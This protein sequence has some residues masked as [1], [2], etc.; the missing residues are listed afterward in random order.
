MAEGSTAQ[1]RKPMAEEGE[2]LMNNELGWIIVAVAI[3]AA[4]VFYMLWS[5]PECP[6]GAESRATRSGWYCTVAPIQRKAVSWTARFP[7]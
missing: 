1:E 5:K 2:A 4:S 3:A 6:S 7:T